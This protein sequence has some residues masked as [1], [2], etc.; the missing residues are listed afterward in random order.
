MSTGSFKDFAGS[1]IDIGPMY[2]FVG[3][4]VLLFIAGLLIW[5]VWHIWQIRLENKEYQ[6][7]LTYIEQ[8]GLLYKNNSAH[9]KNG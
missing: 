8:Q 6:E 9:K 7:E 4:E 1:I 3:Y 2:P 5:L